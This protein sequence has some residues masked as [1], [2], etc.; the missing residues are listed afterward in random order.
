M[1]PLE[2]LAQ[3]AEWAGKNTAYNLKFI[4][5]DKLAWKPA[6]TANSAL[7]IV[8]H[9]MFLVLGITGVLR[10]QEWAAPQM[11]PITSRQQA[12]DLLTTGSLDYAAA[13]RQVNP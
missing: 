5:D 9:V 8:S 13:L 7:E 4:A 3:Q 11:Q 12:Q 6:P 1:H 2:G 10:G